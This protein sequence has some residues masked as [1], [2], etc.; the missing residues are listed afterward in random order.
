[1][2][3]YEGHDVVTHTIYINIGNRG[4]DEVEMKCCREE[5]ELIV[6]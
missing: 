1:M 6:L 2:M 4:D 3:E 5:I